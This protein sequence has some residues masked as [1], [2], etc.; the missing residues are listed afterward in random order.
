MSTLSEQIDAQGAKL[1]LQKPSYDSWVSLPSAT[2]TLIKTKLSNSKN[3]NIVS[4]ISNIELT[5][6]KFE[7]IEQVIAEL[8]SNINELE[9]LVSNGDSTTNTNTVESF[10]NRK[11]DL[12]T[13]VKISLL[14]LKS[15]SGIDDEFKPADSQ[16]KIDKLM[17]TVNAS[18]REYTTLLVNLARRL[19]NKI[20]KDCGTNF[21][22]D[23]LSNKIKNNTVTDKDKQLLREYVGKICNNM[24]KLTDLSKLNPKRITV[25]QF[26]DTITKFV[27]KL[28]TQNVEVII[29]RDIIE[30]EK[31][32]NGDV[33][34]RVILSRIEKIKA[35]QRKNM[36]SKSKL[37]ASKIEEMQNSTNTTNVNP[38]VSDIKAPD[39]VCRSAD[40]EPHDCTSK[41]DYRAQALKF[42]PD[43]NKDCLDMANEKFKKLDN[44]KNCKKFKD[45]NTTDI[46][47]ET[48]LA[49][50]N[51][52]ILKID[53]SGTGVLDIAETYDGENTEDV[54][55]FDEHFSN[56]LENSNESSLAQYLPKNN[57]ED[58]ETGIVSLEEAIDIVYDKRVKEN[59]GN[60]AIIDKAVLVEETDGKG[61]KAVLVEETD[62]KSL[63]EKLEI[64]RQKRNEEQLL[65]AK[66]EFKENMENVNMAQE[67][68]R[69]RDIMKA[70]K[71]QAENIKKMADEQSRLD[72]M[73]KNMESKT[74]A[75]KREREERKEMGYQDQRRTKMQRQKMDNEA[76]KKEKEDE[77]AAKK[78]AE[79]A[80]A[81]ERAD[82]KKAEEEAAAKERA[83]KKA[84]EQAAAKER[85]DKKKADAEAAAKERADKKK[86]DAEAAKQQ[87]DAKNAA[88]LAAKQKQI[89][90]AKEKAAVTAAAKERKER[91]KTN[92]ES[93]MTSDNIH[94]IKAAITVA[95]DAKVDKR[96]IKSAKKKLAKLETSEQIK[97]TGGSPNVKSKKALKKVAKQ[98]AIE[99]AE[100]LEKEKAAKQ[101]MDVK[102]LEAEN[103][104]KIAI[105]KAK[106]IEK[107]REEQTKK[108]LEDAKTEAKEVEK[109][110][111]IIA[112]EQIEAAK[113]SMDVQVATAEAVEK[114]D[115]LKAKAAFENKL[116]KKPTKIVTVTEEI[117]I[118]GDEL[119]LE[120]M[121]TELQTS[122]SEGNSSELLQVLNQ[123]DNLDEYA[124]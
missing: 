11:N 78:A 53:N 85:A 108:E 107:M 50:E 62:G 100:R 31:D 121:L 81:K 14:E 116:S 13:K 58:T 112:D 76:K 57:N 84:A 105:E 47:P 88:L 99:E 51:L 102:I 87:R 7:K 6:D 90:L 86:A 103:R 61:N 4:V 54:I 41:K 49:T 35:N 59:S 19:T 18:Y 39:G 72:Q 83:A 117:D 5:I 33:T 79:Q 71:I 34:E 46:S 65:A 120:A 8:D 21:N 118:D 92:L 20:E 12:K 23:E 114:I 2:K 26:C 69:Q 38:P 52:E 1:F 80:A 75:A 96:I 113:R 29:E 73:R 32:N 25:N 63:V 60:D 70:Q 115:E 64:D 104:S 40:I 28:N 37:K 42:Y 15:I 106:E 74:K 43:R 55:R 56:Y 24:Y 97:R 95:E 66:L 89:Q 17:S 10:E 22:I 68:Q 119:D 101:E 111:E 45:S 27:D 93:I 122:S 98:A 91:A 82:K 94:S 36:E 9:D 16:I 110:N 44:L 109:T 77:K 30:D 48:S 67:E 3:K 123:L 124:P